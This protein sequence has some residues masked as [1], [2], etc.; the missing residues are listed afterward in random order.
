MKDNKD[1]SDARDLMGSIY[2]DYEKNGGYEKLPGMG[3]P[4]P[5]SALQGDIFTKIVKNAGYVPAWIKMQKDIKLRI[6]K[7]MKLNNVEQRIVEAE[8]INQEILKYNRAC[9]APL[10]KNLLS[11][12]EI[13]KHYKLWE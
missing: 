12:D 1:D 4:L 2:K 5:K 11:L 7:L 10:Q 6:E 9:P 13:E 3:K 8:R